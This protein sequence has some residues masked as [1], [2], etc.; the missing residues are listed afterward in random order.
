MHQFTVL[1]GQEGIKN[2][3]DAFSAYSKGQVLDALKNLQNGEQ[4]TYKVSESATESRFL[5]F[6]G[7]V[8]YNYNNRYFFDVTVRNDAC[9]RFGKD[10][11]NATFWA[12]GAL[13]KVKSEAFMQPY[14]WINALDF[15][16][17]YGTQG[18]AS[19]GDYTALGLIGKATSLNDKFAT[20]YVQPGNPNL[21]WETQKLLNIGVSGRLWN[22]FDFDISYYLRKTSDMLM[23]VPY[24]Y[25]T[26]FS[27]M[28]SNVGELQ[29]QGVDIKLGVD[30][31]RGKDYFVNFGTTFNYNAMK[32]T[33]LFDGRQRWEI[34]NTMTAYVV[35]KAVMFYLPLYAGVNKETGAPMWYKAGD[36]VDVTTKKE[37]T[38]DFNEAALTQNSGKKR[39]APV[40]GGF[41]ISAG[42]KGIT[43]QADFSYV[44]GKY[45]VNN[46]AF[47][48]NNPGAVSYQFNQKKNTADYWTEDNKNAKFPNWADG[49]VMNFDDH[50]LENASFLRLKNLQIGYQLPKSVLAWQNALNGVKFTA[51]ARN[52][53][54]ITNYS[55]IDPEVDSNLTYGKIG[56]SKQFLFGIEL[57]F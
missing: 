54:T 30:I 29:N 27:S 48:Y 53:F 38:E 52:L 17:S 49:Y 43:L 50:L 46:D 12:A 32:V 28:T 25:T 10:N 57:T 40:N 39:F 45:L 22:R 15:K 16:V 7:R 20:T 51:T 2:S 5:S 3:Y 41:N 21:T 42:W 19:I 14:T 34:A 33:K 8:D 56:N 6:F 26:G 23:S 47:F 35:D 11:R 44:L 9:S 36:D 13:W 18:N 24:P 1:A 4:S 55:G 31:V 37:T